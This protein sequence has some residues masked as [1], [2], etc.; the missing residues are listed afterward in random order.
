MLLGSAGAVGL[1]AQG[2]C[3][4]NLFSISS[5]N[6]TNFAANGG[7]TTISWNKGSGGS[8]SCPSFI[9][10]TASW[11]TLQGTNSPSTT[12]SAGVVLAPN[13]SSATR[14]A[15]LT[16]QS[17]PTDS[18]NFT[19]TQVGTTLTADQTNLMFNAPGGVAPAPQT[20][21][22]TASG[23]AVQIG[24]LS[25]STGNWLQASLNSPTTPA[26]LTA[27]AN[28]SGLAA[29]SYQGAIQVAGAGLQINISVTLTVTSA[30]CG[31]ELQPRIHHH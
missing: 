19:I 1:H 11:L 2:S 31:F 9:T 3:S 21:N 4:S 20:V 5:S 22:I 24:A 17:S 30:G 28:P 10:T 29:G 15:V 8:N 7:S 14:T 16:V 13:L 27:S 23:G 12:G 6:G 25:T 26:V 18:T